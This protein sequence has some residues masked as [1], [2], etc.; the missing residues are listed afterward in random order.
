VTL[1]AHGHEVLFALSDPGR[2][3]VF[4]GRVGFDPGG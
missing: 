3:R 2:G 4:V 1:R